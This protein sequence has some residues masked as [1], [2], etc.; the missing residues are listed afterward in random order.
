MNEMNKSDKTIAFLDCFSGISGDMFLGALLDA[1]LPLAHLQKNL[2]LLPIDDFRL[3]VQ[4]KQAGAI[5][6]TQLHIEIAAEAGHQH[7]SWATISKL[8]EASGLDLKIKKNAL[9]IFA[10]LAAAEA[11]VHGCSVEDIHFHEVG[12]T[13][14]IVDIVGAAI[15]VNYFGID[16]IVSSPLPMP[17]GWVRC[18]HGQLPLPAP[19]V[20][21]ILKDVPVYGV[22]LQQE[23]VTPTGAAIVKALAEEFGPMPPMAIQA[24]GYGAGSRELAGGQPNLLRLLVG[25]TRSVAE[26]QQVEIIETHVDDWAAEGFPYLCERLFCLGALDVVLIPVLMK[27]GRP[28]YILRVVTD[29]AQAFSLKQCIFSETTAIGLRSRKEDR[30]TLPRRA[31][32]VD[33]DLGRLQVKEVETPAGVVLT[34]EYE[35]CREVAA[36]KNVPLREVYAAVGRCTPADFMATGEDDG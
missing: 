2:A 34:P 18:A 26:A 19:A 33:T 6:G 32:F 29:P 10:L 12:A 13:D 21:E 9:A 4:S 14:A 8:I 27:K 11:R 23:L 20:C 15:G 35:S 1:G 16:K 22:A 28:G 30:W 5:A 31:G 3:T 7:R 25:I 17:S 36:L 24:V